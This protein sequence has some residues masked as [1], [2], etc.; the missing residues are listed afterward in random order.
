MGIFADRIKQ[1]RGLFTAWWIL[2][3]QRQYVIDKIKAPLLKAITI[4]ASRY[5][6]PAKEYTSAKNTHNLLDIQKEFFDHEDNAG[7]DALFR[8]IWRIFIIEYEH[9]TYYRN[10]IDWVIE[11]IVNMSNNGTWQQ[12]AKIKKNWKDSRL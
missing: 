2:S 3:H 6:E 5:P 12:R 8:A 1:A 7:R 11:K 10:R 9:D 4:L